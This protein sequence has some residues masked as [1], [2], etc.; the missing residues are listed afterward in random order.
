MAAWS[1]AALV[2][3]C[4]QALAQLHPTASTLDCGDVGDCVHR[5]GLPNF[6][7]RQLPS[8]LPNRRTAEALDALRK[9][10]AWARRT[11]R[12]RQLQAEI[13]QL[14]CDDHHLLGTPHFLR[15]TARFLTGPSVDSPRRV[16]ERYLDANADLFEITSKD[17]EH[18][19]VVR[20]FGTHG[21]MHHLTFQQT[22]GGIDLYGN[23]MRT[24]VTS[25]GELINVSSVIIP[26]PAGG[27]QIPEAR[28]TAGEA[29]A[30]AAADAGVAIVTPP[31]AGPSAGLE[32]KTAWTVG[33]EFDVWIPVTTRRVYFAMTRDDLRPAYVVI[34]PTR[35]VGHTYE[36][37]IDATTGGVLWRQNYLAW[38][39]TQPV[40]YRYYTSDS[41]APGSPGTPTPTGAQFPF[42]LRDLVTITPAM[43][44]AQ[45]PNGW[46]P[47][48]G[49][50]TVG[51]NVDAYLDTAND[52][53]ASA[54]DRATESAPRV[55][56]FAMNLN[57]QN[58]PTD[59]PLAYRDAAITNAFVKANVYHDRL[60][61][62][63]FDEAAGNFQLDNFGLGGAGNDYV[64]MEV[65]DGGGTNN[66][67]FSTPADGSLPRCQMY[68]WTGPTPDRDGSFDAEIVY[69][70]LTHGTSNRC[71]EI[72][73]TGVQARGMG[74]GWGD[75]YGVCLNAEPTDDFAATY[76]TGGHST[77]QLWQSGAYVNNYYFGIRRFPYSIDENKNPQ[78]YA[79]VDFPQESYPGSVPRNPN[80]ADSSTSVHNKGEV[81]CNAL[82]ECRYAISQD[83]GFAANEVIMQLVVD[84][85]KLAPGNPNYLQ[86]RDAIIQSDMVRYAGAH[87]TRLWEGFA[88][89]G[90]G[91]SATSPTGGATAG[92]VEAF[93]VPQRVLFAYPD[94]TPTQLLPATGTTLRVTM[95]PDNLTL[96]PGT[97]R[98]FVSVNGGAFTSSLM[99][100]DG[101]DTFV[102]VIP[103]AGCFDQVRYYVQTGTS[104]GNRVSPTGAPAAFH[105][106]QVFSNTVV[107]FSDSMETNTGW[108]VGPNTATLGLWERAD[109]QGTAAQP[110]D[111]TTPTPGVMCWVT[112]AQAGTGVGSFDVDGG[113]TTLTTPTINMSAGGDYTIEYQRW[114]NN[115]NAATYGDPWL[116]DISNNNGASWTRFEEIPI[117]APN[118]PGWVLVSKTLSSLG[119]TPTAQMKLRFIADDTVINGVTVASIVEA[120]ID[121]FRVFR[122]E[123]TPPACDG[124]VN[125]DGSVN[126]VDVEIQELAVGGVLDDYCQADA[127]FNQDG[128]VNGLDVEAVELV[129]GGGPCP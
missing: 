70:E 62:M 106:A 69:H 115:N 57:A 1:A 46:I 40:T 101:A 48:G 86:E 79:D 8:E 114:Y 107:P 19:R 76:T 126:G 60:R 44:Q 22:I 45:S 4:G 6:D 26:E 42:V 113:Y 54:A 116:V 75:F 52:N 105:A 100:P 49:T 91:Y 12:L 9:T 97:Q 122:N 63:G 20:D 50:Q 103:G 95:T 3:V 55:Y 18:T 5:V 30:A 36:T 58:M 83:L 32:E 118:Q 120:A 56:D 10:E 31:K 74:E 64:R 43:I 59:E 14:R 87:T 17:L 41:P 117:G 15:S 121:D 88:D 11:A 53:A 21:I 109:P 98:L 25:R 23:I 104:A 119:V 24:N 77:Y 33:P 82:L 129:V 111:D 37:V 96:T 78:T 108:T 125:C 7:A 81:W 124:D 38:D 73:L 51:N 35:G 90:M 128:A 92:I 29:L 16:V 39:T 71:H 110:E 123:C 99:S 34:V 127:D 112:G 27:W 28:L 61:A 13:P 67:N 80:V 93:D 94:G 72:T 2:M 102:G 68:R 84:G 47:D 89:S 85:M 65:Q 66:A